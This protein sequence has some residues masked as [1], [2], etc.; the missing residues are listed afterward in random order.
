MIH[1]FW[2]NDWNGIMK[3]IDEFGQKEGIGYVP[4]LDRCGSAVITK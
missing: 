1:D 3:A 2:N 4:I